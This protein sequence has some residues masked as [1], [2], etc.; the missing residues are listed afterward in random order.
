MFRSVASIFR[1]WLIFTDE[2]TKEEAIQRLK[3]LQNLSK[4]QTS[5]Q[6]FEVGFSPLPVKLFFLS[7]SVKRQRGK[8][9]TLRGNS[10]GLCLPAYPYPIPTPAPAHAVSGRI[11]TSRIGKSR[12][13]SHW[14]LKEGRGTDPR[15]SIY[16][17]FILAWFPPCPTNGPDTLHDALEGSAEHSGNH[18][19]RSQP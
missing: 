13:A 10:D 2:E 18:H 9:V 12:A 4:I 15:L 17:L 6:I 5:T 16:L 11:T 8:E 19:S 1:N 14:E 7:R 3:V